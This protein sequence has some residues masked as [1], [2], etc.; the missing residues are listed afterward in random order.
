M[1]VKDLMRNEFSC[2][3]LNETDVGFSNKFKVL[4][5]DVSGLSIEDIINYFAY[6]SIFLSVE[7]SSGKTF[8][9]GSVSIDTPFEDLQKKYKDK[10]TYFFMANDNMAC[11]KILDNGK[12]TRKVGSY[13][14]IAN[15]RISCEEQTLGKPCDYELQTGKIY[16]MKYESRSIDLTKEDVFNIIDFYIGF[17]NLEDEK[18]VSKN[19]YICVNPQNLSSA[20][21]WFEKPEFLQGLIHIRNNNSL[22][23]YTYPILVS[24]EKNAL[25]YSV[26]KSRYRLSEMCNPKKILK[27]NFFNS[28]K[29]VLKC[30]DCRGF[31]LLSLSDFICSLATCIAETRSPF[32]DYQ[33]NVTKIMNSLNKQK[34]YNPKKSCL[35]YFIT[36]Y[37]SNQL[38]LQIHCS[39][40]NGEEKKPEFIAELKTFDKKS[41][42]KFYNQILDYVLG[43]NISSYID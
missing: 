10:T 40:K 23:E 17:S 3:F 21:K 25:S 7:F 22:C 13:G 20:M 43:Q 34:E 1:F 31:D 2:M 42:I 26:F 33:T 15:G 30:E 38:V 35:I 28:K 19:L 9:I 14:K 12:I 16:K 32:D 6:R 29:D 27:I 8:V 4:D 11:F 24:N 5:I 36:R 39:F 37:S 18:I 41:V